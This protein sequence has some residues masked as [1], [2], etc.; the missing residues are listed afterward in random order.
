MYKMMCRVSVAKQITQHIAPGMDRKYQK[1][2]RNTIEK[3]YTFRAFLVS[4]FDK[5]LVFS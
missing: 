1:A 3:A 2:A 4:F 5:S